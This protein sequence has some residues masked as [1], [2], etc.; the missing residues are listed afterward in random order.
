MSA[1]VNCNTKIQRT[2]PETGGGGGCLSN[3][4]N[5]FL[6]DAVH[7]LLT[8]PVYSNLR[9]VCDAAE[10]LCGSKVLLSGL[11]SNTEVLRGRVVQTRLQLGL[12]FLYY[13]V[14]L[15]YKSE[16]FKMCVRILKQ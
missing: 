4:G 6:S 3:R 14:Q 15:K 16:M 13:D 5:D 1:K 7:H 8:F 12:F 11:Q 9:N 2:R 10:R